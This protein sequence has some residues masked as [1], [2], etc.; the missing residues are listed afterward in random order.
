MVSTLAFPS[1]KEFHW[2][3][4]G[5]FGLLFVGLLG[6]VVVLS[7]PEVTLFFAGAIYILASILW[8]VLVLL[9]LMKGPLR[10]EESSGGPGDGR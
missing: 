5:G 1:F 7:Q 9:G 3:S 10:M 2:R 8:N 6:M 4:R